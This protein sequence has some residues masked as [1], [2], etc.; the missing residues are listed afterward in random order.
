MK[1]VA[2]IFAILAS[3]VYADEDV[4]VFLAGQGCTAGPESRSEELSD[5]RI[6]A[7]VQSALDDNLAVR[8]GDY[9]VL[10]ASICTMQ[11]PEIE[12]AWS[13]DDPRIEAIISDVDA[14]PGDPGCYLMDPSSVFRD[15]Y[16]DN[17][18][19]ANDEFI[20]FLAKHIVTGEIRFYSPDPLRTPVSYQVVRGTCAEVPNINDLIATQ[21]YVTDANFDRYVRAS[22]T[23]VT[24][25]EGQSTAAWQTAL[26]MQGVDLTT[27]E[28]PD[29]AVNAFL[30]MELMILA[31]AAG[32]RVDMTMQDRGRLR[33]PMCGLAQ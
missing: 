25:S 14:Y 10:D 24:C 21:A 6:M 19:R 13:M 23:D 8:T 31:W 27:S 28:G 30:S 9:I 3:P 5:A 17:S 16:P 4:L 7:F 1:A 11:L 18:A 2:A 33:P 32:F 12:D 20:A 29:H 22:G 26:E 15:V